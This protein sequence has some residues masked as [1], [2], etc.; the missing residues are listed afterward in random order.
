MIEL[1]RTSRK[2]FG[3]KTLGKFHQIK[4]VNDG[5]RNHTQK[6]TKDPKIFCNDGF[7]NS[8]SICKNV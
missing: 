6:K 3:K 1:T 8:I 4:H 5:K 2:R 7:I